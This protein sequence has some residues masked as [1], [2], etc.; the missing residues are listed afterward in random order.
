MRIM[1]HRIKVKEGRMPRPCEKCGCT[2]FIS[3]PI[4]YGIYEVL[5]GRLCFQRS[6]LVNEELQLYCRECSNP[7]RFGESEI[8]A[9]SG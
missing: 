8:E 7:L 5:G 6:E 2:T 9:W 3:K 4:K 1:L